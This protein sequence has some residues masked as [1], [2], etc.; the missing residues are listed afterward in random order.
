VNCC[1]EK[2]VAEAG[3]VWEPRGWGMSDVKAATKQRLVKTVT[4]T[5][6]NVSYSDL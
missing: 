1:C 5:R 2:L 4:L 3:V 6:P